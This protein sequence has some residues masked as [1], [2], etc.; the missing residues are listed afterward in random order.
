MRRAHGGTAGNGLADAGTAAS[1]RVDAGTAA[2]TSSVSDREEARVGQKEGRVRELEHCPTGISGLDLVTSGGLPRGRNTLVTGG[3]GC[4]KTL[5]ATE[6]LI[7]GAEMGEPGVFI[8]FEETTDELTTNAAGLGWD[9]DALV[10]DGLLVMDFVKVERD[11]IEQT[12]DYDLEALFVRIGFAI[13]RIGA[14]RVAIDTIEVLFSA[15]GESGILRAELRR[16]FAWLKAR[17]VTA[18][19]TAERGDGSLTRHGIEEYVSDCVIVLD[20]RVTDQ[21]ATRRLRV[22]KLRG[23]QHL[24]GELPFL[25]GPGGFS[26]VPVSAFELHHPAPAE[27]VS[28]GVD[29]LDEMLDRGGWYRGSTTLISGTSGTGKSTLAA[30]FAAA[31]CA[32]GER[33]LFLAF[34]EGELQILRNMGSV[35]LDLGQW[36][37]SD[38]LRIRAT[39]PTQAGLE[40]HLTALY[41]EVESFRPD[42]VVVDPIT[43]FHAMGSSLDIK[44]M[45]MR[46]VDYLKQRQITAVFTSL[47]SEREP[48]DPTISS[49]I[50]SWVHVRHVQKINER[51]RVLYVLKARGMG[52]SNQVRRFELTSSGIK[53]LEPETGVSVGAE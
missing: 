30:H 17:G 44:A 4:G 49:L 3:P 12:G 18:V 37:E 2:T 22:V 41:R 31:A 35:G 5:L 29:A 53:L 38:N 20:H 46:M 7:R 10:R 9:L 34:E 16:L 43:D 23:A 19:I 11:Q 14:K 45:L 26:V 28:T 51:Q 36:V 15:L 8:A 42:V 33:C 39:R 40:N 47:I 24:S 21:L 13:D 27:V 25:I 50:D 1:V 32:R 48:E 6:F 52:H